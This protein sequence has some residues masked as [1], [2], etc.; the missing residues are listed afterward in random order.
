MDAVVVE[1][2]AM[3]A[4]GALVT[5]GKRVL[6]GQLWAGSPAKHVRDLSDEERANLTD[7][8]KHYAN[9]AQIYRGGS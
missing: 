7:G 5:P 2:G 1:T 3:V 9:L 6:S 8:A 4:A